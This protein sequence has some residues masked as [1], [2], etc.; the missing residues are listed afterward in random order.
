[1]MS[2]IDLHKFGDVIFE[3]THKTALYYIIKFG[4]MIYN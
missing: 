3:I 4:H 1:M 2:W